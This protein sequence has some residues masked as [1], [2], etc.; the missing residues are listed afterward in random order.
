MAAL[1][2]SDLSPGASLG[3]CCLTGSGT[4]PEEVPLRR[5]PFPRGSGGL[6]A[7]LGKE[8]GRGLC[9]YPSACPFLFRLA[10]CQDCPGVGFI[11]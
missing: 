3:W 7:A 11:V 5:K 8:V 6:S 10:P 1:G 2:C 4:V 9:W